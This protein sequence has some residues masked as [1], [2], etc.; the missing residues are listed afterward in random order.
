MR[1]NPDVEKRKVQQRLI[2]LQGP[3]TG[4]CKEK[5]TLNQHIQSAGERKYFT[6]HLN[7][8]QW[9]DNEGQQG[10]SNKGNLIVS[11]NV[12][13]GSILFLKTL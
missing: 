8:C 4:V 2:I 3:H 5:M 7:L 6:F 13:Q 11:K 12:Y 10:Q 9:L 1:C